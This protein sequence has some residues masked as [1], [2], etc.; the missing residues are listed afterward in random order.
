[1]NEAWVVVLNPEGS[2]TELR[3]DAPPSWLG[4]NI[5]TASPLP[6]VVRE[7]GRFLVA[8]LQ[9]SRWGKVEAAYVA[10]TNGEVQPIE[11]IAINPEGS[12]L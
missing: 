6:A 8:R 4:A 10:L 3:G 2:V 7:A 11:V 1:M 9:K 5:K 12:G